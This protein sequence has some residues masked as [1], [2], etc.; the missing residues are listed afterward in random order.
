MQTPNNLAL[1]ACVLAGVVMSVLVTPRTAKADIEVRV[2]KDRPSLAVGLIAPRPGSFPFVCDKGPPTCGL[3][4]PPG[5]YRV[6]VV[7]DRYVPDAAPTV[8]ITRDSSLRISSGSYALREGGAAILVAGL[9]LTALGT[10]TLTMS[11][12]SQSDSPG[13]S[14]APAV[15]LGVGVVVTITGI[16]MLGR[17]PTTVHLA[18]LR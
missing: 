14:T 5:K 17:A 12:A 6:A 15:I 10:F 18:Q 4:V 13:K 3:T 9:A 1:G 8:S 2:E 16:V 7:G 11:Y